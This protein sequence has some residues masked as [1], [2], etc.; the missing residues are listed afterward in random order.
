MSEYFNTSDSSNFTNSLDQKG[1]KDQVD[2]DDFLYKPIPKILSI[3]SHV[4]HGYVG[5]RAACFPLQINGW[6]VDI[7]NTV[8]YSNHTG[9]GLVKGS[10][11]E[12]VDLENIFQN[13][14]DLDLVNYNGILTG[15]IPNDK[16][17]SLI[18]QFSQKIKDLNREKKKDLLWL[19]D[20][21]MGDEG[22]LYVDESVVPIYRD[23]ILVNDIDIITPNQ[24][25]AELL[26]DY[27][28]SSFD[29]LKKA[30]S[31]F[32]NNFNLKYVIITSIKLN[33]KLYCACSS[34]QNGDGD[35]NNNDNDNDNDNNNDNDNDNGKEKSVVLFEI[36]TINS[37]FTGVGDLFS[38]L[39]IDKIYNQKDNLIGCVNEVLTIMYKVLNLTAILSKK[40]IELHNDNNSID[41]GKIGDSDSMKYYELRII[42]SRSFYTQS[43]KMY[44]AIYI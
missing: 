18:S 12:K 17:L 29:D 26:L 34:L 16:S 44:K 40:D 35:G 43:E 25:E 42:E 1:S 3:Q 36:K 20:P 6:D 7:F 28:I 15:Y 21:V 27:S 10:I 9:Y 4:T 13:L 8:N 38:A 24:F 32:H 22:I 19:L 5:N 14:L 2:L 23:I 30:F 11:T 41:G 31:D 39:V 33:D 37:Y